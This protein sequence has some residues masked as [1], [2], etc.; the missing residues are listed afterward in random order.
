[1]IPPQGRLKKHT[2][3]STAP[4]KYGV[5]IKQLYFYNRNHNVFAFFG[6]TFKK[7]DS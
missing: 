7:I 5:E 1:M 3:P 2:T 6:K 4:H